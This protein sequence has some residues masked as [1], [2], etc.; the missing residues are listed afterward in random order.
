MLDMYNGSITFQ[1]RNYIVEELQGEESLVGKF[2][3]GFELDRFT[4]IFVIDVR[5]E[6]SG[7][8][9]PAVFNTQAECVEFIE[10]LHFP[11]KY[12]RAVEI[13]SGVYMKDIFPKVGGYLLY[14]SK[15]W[16]PK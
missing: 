6:G 2:A 12:L 15:I 1:K 5:A 4:K 10:D 13:T 9:R 3:I 16:L 11:G 7:I 14:K 8:Q